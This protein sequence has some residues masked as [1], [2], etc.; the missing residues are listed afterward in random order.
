MLPEDND[1]KTVPSACC[2]CGAG[3]MNEIQEFKK[4]RRVTSDSRPWRAGGRLF[5]CPACGFAQK[6][7]DPG[8][9]EDAKKIYDDYFLYYQSGGAEQKFF[10]ASGG[11]V[12]RTRKILDYLFGIVKMPEAG[13]MLDIG[14][15]GGAMLREF[16]A[17][18]TGWKLAGSELDDRRI[19]LIESIERVEKL[20]VCP[21]E[22]IPD[23]FDLVSMI[24][25]L[26]HI[27]SPVELLRGIHER[28]NPAGIF[29]AQVPN[30]PHNPFDLLI[31]DHCLHFTVATAEKL[32]NDSGFEPVEITGECIPREITIIARKSVAAI[33]KAEIDAGKAGADIRRALDWLEETSLSARG[34]A[35]GGNFGLFGTA[36]AATWLFGE[37]GEDAVAFF[38]DEDPHRAGGTFLGRPVLHPRDVPPAACVFI[39]MPMPAAQNIKDKME[40]MHGLRNCIVPPNYI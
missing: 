31:T 4:F 5:I 9:I 8:C 26:E 14:C 29:L 3:G 11:N 33:Q 30:V 17:K 19:T 2:L 23:S 10:D 1:N 38:V 6:A 22:Q 7:A 25:V 27:F 32:I 24:Y 20:Y 16:S 13:R 36:I 39:G 28:L 15:G 40:N 18:A 12:P 34:A 35:A 37:L 21:P